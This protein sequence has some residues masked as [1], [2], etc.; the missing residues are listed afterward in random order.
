[1]SARDAVV[2]AL[3]VA[4]FAILAT[5]H[6][7]V[8]AGLLAHRPRWRGLVALVVVPLA[9][10]WAMRERMRVRGAL[11]IGAAALYAVARVAAAW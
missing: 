6:V 10:Y 1:M 5:L 3:V 8:V 7:V 2:V 9:P 4:S 11:W